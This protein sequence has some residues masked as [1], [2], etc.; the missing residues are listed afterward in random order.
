MT[1]GRFVKG[2]W[3]GNAPIT[4]PVCVS[5]DENLPCARQIERVAKLLD[6]TP[7]TQ[8]EKAGQ[9]IINGTDGHW[10]RLFDFIEMTLLRMK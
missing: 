6:L 9:I 1:S 10:Y 7:L 5:F 2:E 8:E 4:I 3:I